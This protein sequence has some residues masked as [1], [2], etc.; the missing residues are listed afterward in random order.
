MREIIEVYDF[1]HKMNNA[2]T[3]IFKK[4]LTN[5]IG[6]NHLEILISSHGE[7]I[8]EI[9]VFGVGALTI[10]K[11]QKLQNEMLEKE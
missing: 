6:I 10:K 3:K 7:N 1:K 4:Y 8:N 11:L 5:E 9:T 2:I